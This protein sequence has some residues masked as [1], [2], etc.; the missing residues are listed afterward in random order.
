MAATTEVIQQ[1][2][3]GTRS[4][5]AD[6]LGELGDKISGTV[7]AVEA[8][9]S[10]V[11]E[12]A[13]D[14]VEA[15][16]DTVSDTVDSVRETV[17]DTVEAVKGAFDLHKQAQE[18]PW[19]VFGGAVALGFIGT[20][21]LSSLT[22]PPRERERRPDS[23]R[24]GRAEVKTAKT[25]GRAAE[26]IRAQQV[27]SRPAEETEHQD[28]APRPSWLS[29]FAKQFGPEMSTL[30]G[31]ALGSVFG[32]VRDMVTPHLPRSLKDEVGNVIN[33]LTEDVGGKTIQGPVLGDSGQPN[34]EERSLDS[35]QFT[36]K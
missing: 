13:S 12:K 25:N 1:D 36:N 17:S 7:G 26:S 15:V 29:N 8:T 24:D 30:K 32:V 18:R 16:K 10:S 31:L 14:T 19:L 33:K 11:S 22:A 5:L 2:M 27:F 3:E 21:L 28:A 20:K 23:H 9:V 34:R 6:K 35:A 4:G